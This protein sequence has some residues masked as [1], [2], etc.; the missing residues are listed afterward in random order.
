MPTVYLENLKRLVGISLRGNQLP[1]RDAGGES[2]VT[3][4]G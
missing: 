4:K 1:G 3:A 2:S